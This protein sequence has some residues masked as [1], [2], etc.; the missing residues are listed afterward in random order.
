MLT[1]SDIRN[2]A[3]KRERVVITGLGLICALGNTAD[4]CFENAKNGKN[5][6][7]KTT[8]VD[9]EGCYADLAAEVTDKNVEKS[10][11]DRS[12]SLAL[13]AVNEAISDAKITCFG[14]KRR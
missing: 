9:T 6:I 14:E 13:H 2:N 1:S 5:G 12:V 4:E 8:T 10:G 7:K 11:C 3:L